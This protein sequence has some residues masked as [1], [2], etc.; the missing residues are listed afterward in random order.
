MFC[1]VD[2]KDVNAR[3]ATNQATMDGG[4]NGSVESPKNIRR[5]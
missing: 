5:V 3:I 1:T 2:Y 4:R